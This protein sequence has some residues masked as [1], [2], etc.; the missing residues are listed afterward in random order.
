[1][2]FIVNKFAKIMYFCETNRI[3]SSFFAPIER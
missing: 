3:Y 2:K 1:M